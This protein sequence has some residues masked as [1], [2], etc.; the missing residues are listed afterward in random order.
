MNT[1]LSVSVATLNRNAD[2]FVPRAVL[3]TCRQQ[4]SLLSQTFSKDKLEDKDMVRFLHH[5]RRVRVLK[6]VQPLWETTTA[7][8]IARMRYETGGGHV[9]LDLSELRPLINKEC[10]SILCDYFQDKPA[11]PALLIL[12]CNPIDVSSAGHLALFFSPILRV[13]KFKH[14]RSQYPYHIRNILAELAKKG[15]VDALEV[16]EL[17]EAGS[18]PSVID[19]KEMKFLAILP[20]LCRLKLYLD[21][22]TEYKTILRRFPPASFP[23]LRSLWVVC[24]D[25]RVEKDVSDGDAAL[26]TITDLLRYLA[27]THPLEELIYA[28]P[29]PGYASRENL[30]ALFEATATF[31]DTLRTCGFVLRVDQ[32]KD[33]PPLDWHIFEPLRRIRLLHEICVA[34]LALDID[35]ADLNAMKDVW[36]A[37]LWLRLGQHNARSPSRIPVDALPDLVRGLPYLEDLGVPVHDKCKPLDLGNAEQQQV[38]WLRKLDVGCSRLHRFLTV[39]AYISRSFPNTTP[40]ISTEDRMLR[41]AWQGVVEEEQRRRK[42]KAAKVSE[43]PAST[44]KA[45]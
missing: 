23:S 25:K 45:E 16:L 38:P 29:A 24:G 4:I 43:G 42:E 19:D 7:V 30:D 36:P 1:D 39:A 34:K 32:R 40:T 8:K 15:C 27:P 3:M 21:P 10:F 6:R 13:L 11:L 35:L 41:Y 37:L 14:S 22:T 20:R 5:A 28:V 33:Q 12:I 26:S 17:S 31:A 2:G 18:F 44:L 9:A